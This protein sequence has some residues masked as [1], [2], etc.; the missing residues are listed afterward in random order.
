MDNL[1]KSLNQDSSRSEASEHLRTFVLPPPKTAR[2]A[3]QLIYNGDFARI[4]NIT[5]EN[6]DMANPIN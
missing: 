5:E 6:N 2:K 3:Y 4:L 1:R